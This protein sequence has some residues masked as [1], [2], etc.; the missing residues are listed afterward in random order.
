MP[1][2][3]TFVDDLA[4][5]SYHTVEFPTEPVSLTVG[6]LFVSD[7][8]EICADSLNNT[9]LREKNEERSDG[10]ST[11]CSSSSRKTSFVP[12]TDFV[13]R[14]DEI[15]IKSNEMFK[16]FISTFVKKD[17]ALESVPSSLKQAKGETLEGTS[18]STHCQEVQT[19]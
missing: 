10:R 4:V 5:Q 16:N 14:F 18:E 8:S 12:K 11:K 19:S 17:D 9:G 2:I 7:D 1:R 15:K 6:P 13:G 3:N